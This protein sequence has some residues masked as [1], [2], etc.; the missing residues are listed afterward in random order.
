MKNLKKVSCF[1]LFLTYAKKANIGSLLLLLIT[2]RCSCHDA[3]LLTHIS[4]SIFLLFTFLNP[5]Y[6]Y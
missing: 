2:I 5:S 3:H 1:F 6:C 4:A